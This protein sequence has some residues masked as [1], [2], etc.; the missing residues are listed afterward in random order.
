MPVSL[1]DLQLIL[2]R[3]HVIF[4]QV[5]EKW[6]HVGQIGGGFEVGK[7]LRMA[8]VAEIPPELC[9]RWSSALSRF[10]MST[11]EQMMSI[12]D[13]GQVNSELSLS[14]LAAP[15]AEAFLAR[16]KAYIRQDFFALALHD[17]EQA[18][19]C[20]ELDDKEKV[21]CLRHVSEM[22]GRLGTDRHGHVRSQWQTWPVAQRRTNEPLGVTQRALSGLIRRRSDISLD[23]S[24]MCSHPDEEGCDLRWPWE[25]ASP[26][27]GDHLALQIMRLCVQL[28]QMPFQDPSTGLELRDDTFARRCLLHLHTKGVK[29][30]PCALLVLGEG[31]MYAKGVPRDLEAARSCLE[32]AAQ[33]LHKR[34]SSTRLPKYMEDHMN[35]IIANAEA[36]AC[37]SLITLH[38]NS[39]GSISDVQGLKNL[40]RDTANRT[41]SP[42]LTYEVARCYQYGHIWPPNRKSYVKWLKK[43]AGHKLGVA[44][45]ELAQLYATGIEGVLERNR[46]LHDKWNKIG[47]A[48]PD[49]PAFDRRR[50]QDQL[51]N[52]SSFF[53]HMQEAAPA[54]AESGISPAQSISGASTRCSTCG[55]TETE[56]AKLSL[57]SGCRSTR[58]CSKECQ[59][60]AWKEG[61]KL[62]CKAIVNAAKTAASSSS[63]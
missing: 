11:A 8:P 14:I 53:D 23:L 34:E 16:G 26:E 6:A 39:P 19:E 60:R 43:S 18:L 48:D 38:R 40:A 59:I 15:S 55:K 31:L 30:E 58:Y 42:A 13:P 25:A 32:A 10:H 35:R 7:L 57:C 61:H 21:E 2:T 52:G 22:R 47:L 37:I 1:I 44:A 54:F 46:E 56:V 45:L 41:K 63:A 12:N 4:A 3:M 29:L 17:F 28:S 33:E 9:K 50:L 20:D 27:Q 62:A 51:A 24:Q 5:A 49:I 36:D